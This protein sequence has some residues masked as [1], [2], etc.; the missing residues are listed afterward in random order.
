MPNIPG[1]LNPE[2]DEFRKKEEHAAA[3][4][5]ALRPRE[6]REQLMRQPESRACA[7]AKEAERQWEKGSIDLAAVA[8]QISLAWATQ[9][10]R[11][12]DS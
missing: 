11:S 4:G 5:F 2:S 9:I 12:F 7:W 10:D 3:I 1:E 6:E 8:S